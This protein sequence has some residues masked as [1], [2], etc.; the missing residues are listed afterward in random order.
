MPLYSLT[1]FATSWHILDCLA[2]NETGEIFVRLLITLNMMS[3]P[4]ILPS[5][6]IISRTGISQ[7]V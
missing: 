7:T 1:I 5:R 6:H 3:P 2:D 4:G